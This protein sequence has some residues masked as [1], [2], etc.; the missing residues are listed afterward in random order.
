MPSIFV[1]FAFNDGEQDDAPLATPI[2]VTRNKGKIPRT[3]DIAGRFRQFRYLNIWLKY[4][5][6]LFKTPTS[7]R[8]SPPVIG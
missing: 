8:L 4:D 3:F 2:V 5:M 6:K 7:A 1:R